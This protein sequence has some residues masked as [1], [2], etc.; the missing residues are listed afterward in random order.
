M[1]HYISKTAFFSLFILLASIPILQAQK[2]TRTEKTNFKKSLDS[3][4]LASN[5]S[6]ESIKGK[7]VMGMDGVYDT[8]AKTYESKIHIPEGI[9]SYI[10]SNNDFSA[11]NKHFTGFVCLY[12]MNSDS[13]VS[14]KTYTR[15]CSLVKSG[16]GHRK[17]HLVKTSK[18]KGDGN[19]VIVNTEY[20]IRQKCKGQ[21][22]SASVYIY[23]QPKEYI[24]EG[25]RR[26]V[27]DVYL[28]V[29]R[30]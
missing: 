17:V 28:A 2:I 18:K 8:P 13:A 5:D 25:A 15:V 19:P 14:A 9:I 3:I 20:N 23:I 16:L 26:K 6:F 24:A 11:E 30:K 12:F 10:W 27:Y 21:I 1:K 29:Y 4:I 7:F 22:Q